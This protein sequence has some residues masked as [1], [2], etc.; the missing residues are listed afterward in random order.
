MYKKRL[1]DVKHINQTQ[2]LNKDKSFH[3]FFFLIFQVLVSIQSLILV[4]EPYFNEPG[5][6]R[7]KGKPQGEQNS[8][9]YNTNI[10]QACVKW[11]ILEQIKKPSACFKEV[12]NL[13]VYIFVYLPFE[14]F[15]LCTT[16]N[17][18][19]IIKN[20]YSQLKFL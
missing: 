20:Y 17:D 10:R 16:Y 1:H 11:A 5:Y 14:R 6:E 19:Q 7:L 3:S 4:A 18:A 15:S 2:Q 9:D 8:N 13:F 12:F